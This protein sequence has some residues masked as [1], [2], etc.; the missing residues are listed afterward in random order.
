MHVAIEDQHPIHTTALQHEMA[1]H[2][3]VVED[4]ES[5]RVVVM[6]MVSAASQVTGQPMFQR[7]LG[8]QQRT[9]DR[10]HRAPRQGFAP[11]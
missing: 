7:L 11:G 6:R 4:A 1:D 10:P 2:C 3:Q 8:R 5:G 9:T